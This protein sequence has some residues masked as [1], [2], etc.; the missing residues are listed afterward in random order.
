MQLYEVVAFFCVMYDDAG[1]NI[2]FAC[3]DKQSRKVIKKTPFFGYTNYSASHACMMIRNPLNLVE[4][5]LKQGE[6]NS[7]GKNMPVGQYLTQWCRE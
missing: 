6:I 4:L 5:V 2:R 7:G 1:M 3:R